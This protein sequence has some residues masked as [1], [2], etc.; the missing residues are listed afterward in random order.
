MT[1]TDSFHRRAHRILNRP[2]LTA[3][4]GVAVGA[5]YW[6]LMSP[7]SQLLC[8]FP[9]RAWTQPSLVSLTFDD[10]PNEPYTSQIADF[11]DRRG[12]QGTFFQVGKCVERHPDVTER[13]ASAGHVIGNHSYSHDIRKCVGKRAL[14]AEQRQAEHVFL[15][16][17]GRRPALYRPPWLLRTPALARILRERAT[18]P[19]SGLFCHPLE[20]LQPGPERIAR[21][22]LATVRPGCMLIF[23]D[24]FDARGADRSSTVEAVKIVVD[25]LIRS[26]YRFTTVDRLLGVPAYVNRSGEGT[27]ASR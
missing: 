27:T 23:H 21:Y 26:G 10:G 18:Q 15:Q 9:Y 7:Y 5:S 20:V 22:A 4:L 14:S 16:L 25:R 13:L 17:L 3:G 24:G 11:L 1:S 6:T 8:E 19:V 12:I 2:R